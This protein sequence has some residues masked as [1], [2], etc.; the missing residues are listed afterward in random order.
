MTEYRRKHGQNESEV[1]DRVQ[2]HCFEDSSKICSGDGGDFGVFGAIG[3]SHEDA[4]A[5]EIVEEG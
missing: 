4:F 5:D 3:K 1:F 2:T